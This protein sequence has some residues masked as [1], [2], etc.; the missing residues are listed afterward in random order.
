MFNPVID[1]HHH[2]ISKEMQ[3]KQRELGMEIPSFMPKWTPEIGMQKM[4][5]CDI[6]FSFLSAPSDLTIIDQSSANALARKMNE[7]LASYAQ[8]HPERYGAFATLPLPN[9]EAAMEETLYAFDVLGMDGVAMLTSY[10]GKYLSH[11]DY[12]ELLT[13][14]DRRSAVVFLHPILIPQK[15]AGLS[16]AL[17]EGTFDTTRAVTTMAVHRIFDQYPSIT[18]I[19]PHTGGMVPYIKWRIALA[20]IGQDSIQV[21]TTPEQFQAEIAKLD[22]LYYD[23]TLNLGTIQKLIAPDRILFGADIPWPADSVLRIQRESVFHEAQQISEEN[24][25]MIAYGNA[26]RLFPRISKLFDIEKKLI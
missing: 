25:K 9:P 20:A 11:P 3:R 5:V 23:S 8:L 22:H 10:Q 26:F 2:I 24:A 18:F 19:L 6:S 13:E 21:E 1:V 16:P 17:L 14:L 7:E 4:D 12:T 15:I